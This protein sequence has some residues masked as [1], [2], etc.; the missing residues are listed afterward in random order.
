[1]LSKKQ[2]QRGLTTKFIGRKLFAFE[3]IDSTNACAKTLAEAGCEEGT[4]VIAEFQSH[5]RGR[6]GR[7]WLAEPGQNLLFSIVLRPKIQQGQSPVLIFLS[8]VAVARAV[9][10]TTGV[11]VHCKWPN[12]V[13]I[14]KKKVCGILTESSLT[15]GSF[16]YS[17]VGI[18]LNVNQQTFSNSV[19]GATSVA[20]ELG[21]V[22]DRKALFHNVLCEFEELYQ[23]LRSGKPELILNE[24]NR[25]CSM[26]GQEVTVKTPSA[27]IS[28]TAKRLNEAGGLVLSTDSG[29]QTFYAGDVTI[30]SS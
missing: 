7:T 11:A 13:L 23:A 18:G 24:W 15:N 8:A 27:Q 12:D 17:V 28:G 10:K 29:E 9:E 16:A 25:R 2:L 5:G 26:F 14:N 20:L 30:I 1:M 6:L 19:K 21:K 22:C 4:V 3:S